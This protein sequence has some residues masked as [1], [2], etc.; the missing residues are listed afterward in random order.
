MAGGGWRVAE[1]ASSDADGW[2]QSASHSADGGLWLVVAALGIAVGRRRSGYRGRPW[3][4]R[5]EAAGLCN[6]A[7]LRGLQEGA[8]LWS[9]TQRVMRGKGY[10]PGARERSRGW[11]YVALDH[12]FG[13]MVY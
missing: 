9:R 10:R 13:F 3:P 4:P 2:G 12:V 5:A 8:S 7:L 6:S 1:S 11:L